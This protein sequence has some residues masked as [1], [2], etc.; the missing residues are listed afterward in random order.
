MHTSLSPHT[1][2]KLELVKQEITTY[3][4]SV[5]V[6]LGCDM[7]GYVRPDNDLHWFRGEDAISQSSKYDV[8]FR[9]GSQTA[10]KG[11]TI[12]VPSRLCVLKILHP[13][14]K[15]TGTYTCSINGT[16]KTG[17]VKLLVL[18]ASGMHNATEILFLKMC[19]CVCVHVCAS[20][21]MLK[22]MCNCEYVTV[23]LCTYLC[24]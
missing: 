20:V 4:D 24:T 19:V 22:C 17:Y 1:T 7:A 16:N 5:V 6:E 10:Q 12:P 15:D 9:N 3:N 14:I 11:G 21:C 23:C 2:V 13:E 18:E 8:E